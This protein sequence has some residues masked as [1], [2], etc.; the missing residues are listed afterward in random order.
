VQTRNLFAGNLT[1]HPCFDSLKEGTDYRIAAPLTNTD[2]IMND[3][4]WVG[5]YPGM[6]RARLECIIAS[7]KGLVKNLKR[8]EASCLVAD[9][10][11]DFIANKVCSTFL[12][13]PVAVPCI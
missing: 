5:V 2:K 12:S 8:R 3:S 9:Y 6:N 1:R 4:L 13:S 11:F 7:I 10:V